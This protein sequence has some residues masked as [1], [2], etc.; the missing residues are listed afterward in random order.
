[1]KSLNPRE[2]YSRRVWIQQGLAA[3]TALGQER[4]SPPVP[5]RKVIV[6]GAGLS[7]LVAA[8]ELSNAGHEVTI[9]EA[10]LRLG[11]RVLTLRDRFGDGLYAEAGATRIPDNHL[12]TLQYA[13]LFSLTLDPFRDH[14]NADVVHVGGRRVRIRNAE[15]VDWP[16]PLSPRERALGMNG[17]RA[18]YILPVPAEVGDIT[19]ASWPPDALRKYDQIS[20]VDFLKSRGAS[21]AAI[22]LLN[23]G[24]RPPANQMSALAALRA[25]SWRSKTRNFYKI[26]G[27]NDLLPREFANRLR[28]RIIYGAAVIRMEQTTD[29]VKVVWTRSGGTQ[30]QTCDR[31]VCAI[32]FSVARKL[33]V[34]PPFSPEKRNAIENLQYESVTK[35]FLQTDRRFWTGQ[36]DSGFAVTDLPLTEVW[37]IGSS[38]PSPRGL[39][40]SY[41]TGANA[42]RLAEMTEAG[43]IQSTATQMEAIHPGFNAH[44]EGGSS[45]CWDNDEWARGAYS[46]LS[47]GEAF[48]GVKQALASEGRIHFAGDHTSAWSGWMQGALASGIRAAR[49]INQPKI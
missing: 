10:Q 1:M 37:D 16:L 3:A 8:Y 33:S 13:S 30:F 41:T 23:L 21:T 17:M 42:R 43:R 12:L 34:D 9:I 6:I 2:G 31:V 27:G 7:G 35:V 26:R 19:S 29:A 40:M 15:P 39:L 24:A 18:E 28:G 5:N 20:W 11:G 46:Y 25:Q 22:T 38:Q 45:Y 32:P 49:E 47:V 44:Y 36:G 14:D 48:A 4:T